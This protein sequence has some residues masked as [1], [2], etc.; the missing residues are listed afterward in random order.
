MTTKETV[1][2]FMDTITI[3]SVVGY[4]MDWFTI[5]NMIGVFTLIW[6]IARAFESVM[7]KSLYE[8]FKKD[9]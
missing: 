7:G 4:V 5:P 9:K 3:T 8:F 1:E 2:N 6:A